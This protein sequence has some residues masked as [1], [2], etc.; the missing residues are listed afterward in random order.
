MLN[1]HENTFSIEKSNTEH[2]RLIV[3]SNATPT[4]PWAVK[5]IK[6]ASMPAPPPESEPAIVNAVFKY[7]PL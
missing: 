6:S 4:T 3:K 5:G 1:Y 2:E 7:F